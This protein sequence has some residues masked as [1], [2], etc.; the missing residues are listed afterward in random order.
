MN[1]GLEFSKLLEKKEEFSKL[2]EIKEEYKL[3]LA[4]GMKDALSSI[5]FIGLQLNYVEELLKLVP[6]FD[7]E[8]ERTL[9]NWCNDEDLLQIPLHLR[10]RMYMTWVSDLV[11]A[12]NKEILKL[13]TL[14][15]WR[16]SLQIGKF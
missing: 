5:E 8:Q 16:L 13:E 1:F 6:A 10:W 4:E 14:P 15:I 2:L 12:L 9:I 7:R 3:Q 11:D